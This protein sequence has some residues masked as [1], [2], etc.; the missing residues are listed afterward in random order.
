MLEVD[1]SLTLSQ[2][3]AIARYFAEK[4]QLAGRNEWERAKVNELMDV[5]KDFYGEML[6]WVL[7]VVK[8]KVSKDPVRHFLL[9]F[10]LEIFY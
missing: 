10:H 8:I 6:P 3:V 4:H 9:Q 2:S 1:N 7:H 5:H